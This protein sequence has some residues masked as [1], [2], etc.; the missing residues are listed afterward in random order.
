M[1]RIEQS[2][3]DVL[4][5]VDELGYE[6]ALVGGLAVGVRARP[7]TTLDVDFAVAVRSD[8]EAEGIAFEFQRRGYELYD[9]VEQTVAERLAT[10]R[11]RIE[12]DTGAG[13]EF[14]D[15]LFASSG[16]EPEI[17]AAAD[18]IE[19]LPGFVL[20]VAQRGHLLAI[21]VLA[22]DERRRPQ[23]RLDIMALLAVAGEE[24]LR[25]AREAAALITS[26]GF[27]RDKDLLAELSS[28]AR[29]AEELRRERGD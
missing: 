5:V 2:A 3:H 7:R 21:K 12:H 27:H 25:T 29:Q 22:Q 4:R 28:F 6:S 8:D 1:P 19:I 24:D 15:L 16:I 23:D 26:R 10:A 11:F 13:P 14:V 9:V 18:S 17:V 20:P